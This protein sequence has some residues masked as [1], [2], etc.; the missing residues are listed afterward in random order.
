HSVSSQNFLSCRID[1]RRI[2]C[3]PPVKTPACRRRSRIVYSFCACSILPDFSDIVKASALVEPDID[4]L[5]DQRFIAGQMDEKIVAHAS[6]HEMFVMIIPALR[7]D[8]LHSSLMDCAD[9]S[10]DLLYFS[11]KTVETVF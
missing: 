5:P 1:S 7:E 10:G 4:Q 6:C 3:L 11:Q 2:I 9:L 8:F